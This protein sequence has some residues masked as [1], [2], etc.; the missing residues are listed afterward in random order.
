ML[1]ALSLYLLPALLIIAAASDTLYLR[2]PNWLT[3]GTALAF[4]PMALATGMPWA[5]LGWHALSGLLLFLAGFL[6]FQMRLFGGGDAKL[7]AAAGL[8]FGTQQVLP[9]LFFTVLAG[10]LLALAVAAISMTGV[11][12][13]ITAEKLSRKFSEVKPTVPYG[14]ALAIGG[15]LAFRDSWWMGLSG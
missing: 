9:F 6:L 2:I 14:I 11:H 10:G 3:L 5:D 13:E 8:W 15:I 7:M 4:F 1:H 12:L